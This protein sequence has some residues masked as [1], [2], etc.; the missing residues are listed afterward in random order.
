MLL[1]SSIHGRLVIM[2]LTPSDIAAKNYFINEP[3]RVILFGE[4]GTDVLNEYVPNISLE[5]PGA[6]NFIKEFEVDDTFYPVGATFGRY[7][8]RMLIIKRKSDGALFGRAFFDGFNGE[9][10]FGSTDAD[11][12]IEVDMSNASEEDWDTYAAPYVFLPVRP[13][14]IP[15]YNHV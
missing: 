2:K 13:I 3:D 9:N 14:S 10:D 6:Q 12:E 11:E 7:T 5:A 4:L 15:G 1:S 8:E